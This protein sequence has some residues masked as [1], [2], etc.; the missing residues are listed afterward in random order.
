MLVRMMLA[1]VNGRGPLF[2]PVLVDAGNHII[3]MEIGCKFWE[4]LR[5]AYGVYIIS[6]IG[7]GTWPA[8]GAGVRA[9]G[10]RH[11]ILGRAAALELD[12]ARGS[13][14]A[15]QSSTRRPAAGTWQRDLP[16]CL[17]RAAGLRT[18]PSRSN[19]C[20]PRDEWPSAF[21]RSGAVGPC[22]P[23]TIARAMDSIRSRRSVD[24]GRGGAQLRGDRHALR[25][26]TSPG[27][28]RGHA[29]HSRRHDVR[30]AQLHDGAH[31]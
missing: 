5:Y 18:T 24:V 15:V 14:G 16:P 17:P 30:K 10:Q 27:R 1:M 9:R 2:L 6:H 4:H 31:G 22:A 26:R 19:P 13:E 7:G 21:T 11:Y 12:R 28:R 20:V 23:Q 25:R 29:D 8:G 3:A